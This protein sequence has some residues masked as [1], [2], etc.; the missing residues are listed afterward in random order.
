MITGRQE[1]VLNKLPECYAEIG[2]GPTAQGTSEASKCKQVLGQKVVHLLA[3]FSLVYVGIE[4][5][6]AG[7]YAHNCVAFEIKYMRVSF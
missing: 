6:I 7:A 4:F 3:F 1:L 2:E 5:T